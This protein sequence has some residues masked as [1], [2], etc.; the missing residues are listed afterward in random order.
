MDRASIVLFGLVA[1]LAAVLYL[2]RA[3]GLFA[4]EPPP[5][6]GAF[7]RAVAPDDAE[8]APRPRVPTAFGDFDALSERPLFSPTRRP[9]EA[10]RGG[11]RAE[12]SSKSLD[13]L[14]VVATVEAEERR[15]ALVEDPS[16]AAYFR[17]G[18]GDAFRGW[19]VVSIGDGAA[20]LVRDG[21]SAEGDAV[22]VDDEGVRPRKTTAAP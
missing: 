4:P 13:R 9:D 22:I 15:I 6:I 11:G 12:R 16:A 2:E 10:A 18:L 7:A 8:A 21:R 3:H 17:L 5:Q 14:R 19:R 1:A 20:E